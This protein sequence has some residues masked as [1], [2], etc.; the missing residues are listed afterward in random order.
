MHAIV[1]SRKDIKEYDQIVSL[2][3]EENGKVD[4]LMRGVKKI[5]SKHAAHIEPFCVV[6]ASIVPGKELQ[7]L[8]TIY[9]IKYFKNIRQ[10][11]S[12]SLYAS[13]VVSLLDKIIEPSVVDERI[14]QLTEDYLDTIE[15][16][17][18]PKSVLIDCYIVRLLNCLGLS[19]E[20]ETCVVC[21]SKLDLTSFYFLG[22]GVVCKNCAIEKKKI[23]EKV[24]PWTDELKKNIS[25][26]GKGKWQEIKNLEI[27]QKEYNN[28]HRLIYEFFAFHQEKEIS[29]WKHLEIFKTSNK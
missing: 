27:T 18:Q 29:D 4:C 2:Y 25:L 12:K 10:N 19:P 7:I 21:E 17:K 20:L 1:L 13:Y 26:L 3:T 9:S 6:D 11:V 14:F 22:G 23:F 24:I 8:T 5:V 15:S 16:I 28:L